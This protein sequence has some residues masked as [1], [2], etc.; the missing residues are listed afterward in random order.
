MKAGTALFLPNLVKI[1]DIKLNNVTSKPILGIS[2]LIIVLFFPLLSVVY[3]VTGVAFFEISELAIFFGWFYIGT[4]LA[5]ASL[6]KEKSKK[7]HLIMPVITLV[8]SA[9]MMLVQLDS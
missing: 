2:S 9:F 6:I 4:G 8:I 7:T 3:N 5:I 1:K